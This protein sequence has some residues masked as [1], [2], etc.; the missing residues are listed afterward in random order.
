MWA[1]LFI[2]SDIFRRET[3]G[4]HRAMDTSVAY[5]DINI[6]TPELHF[7]FVR[8]I[9]LP[10]RTHGRHGNGP[11]D[12]LMRTSV[13]LPV[14]LI[15]SPFNFI[16]RSLVVH[17][18]IPAVADP[19]GVHGKVYRVGMGPGDAELVTFKAAKLLKDADC[20]FC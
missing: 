4:N 11:S 5:G 14:K 13:T 18:G 19:A 2:L 20:V 15:R 10:G 8:R 1:G 9:V 7:W 17:P 12:N 16:M 3:A 6:A